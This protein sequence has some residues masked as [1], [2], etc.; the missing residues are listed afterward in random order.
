MIGRK[1]DAFRVRGSSRC[2]ATV[3]VLARRSA[4]IPWDFKGRKPWGAAAWVI[5]LTSARVDSRKE[6]HA[7][8][9]AAAD[10]RRR[11]SRRCASTCAATARPA[12]CS[13]GARSTTWR[14][15]PRCCRR[16]PV[17]AARLEHGRLPR[18]GRRRARRRGRGRRDLPGARRRCWR[19]AC[20][21]G[22]L[23]VAA[24]AAALEALLAAHPLEAA[25][26]AL[27]L[28]VLIQHAEGDESVPV[29][30]SRA[31]APLLRHPASRLDVSR[32]G[33]HRSV[34]HD[35][36]RR[37]RRST[38]CARRSRMSRFSSPSRRPT[39]RSHEVADV[40]R[41]DRRG[42]ARRARAARVQPRVRRRVRRRR[43]RRRR[44]ATGPGPR[45]PTRRGAAATA[46]RSTSAARTDRSSRSTSG[47]SSS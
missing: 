33:D 14:P 17:R 36:P 3:T 44:R 8:M 11:A 24:D 13:T 41:H 22:R 9:A 19:A 45:R 10:A 15:P 39:L 7:D 46:G 21:T 2:L 30:G 35:P 26:A 47:R 27:E 4:G 18:A 31:L 25:V 40:R 5:L 29:A 16:A 12:A 43:R 1:H 34:Q 6:N 38:G 20:A 32:G 28:P 37:R 42:G 23:E